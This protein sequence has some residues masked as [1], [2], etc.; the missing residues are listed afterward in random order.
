[1]GMKYDE[2]KEGAI[3]FERQHRVR[4][5]AKV[6]DVDQFDNVTPALEI[7]YLNQPDHMSP[8]LTGSGNLN[9][10]PWH[11]WKCQRELIDDVRLNKCDR[12]RRVY[13]PDCHVCHC[14]TPWDPN[15]R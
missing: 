3:Y 5:L 12:C 1:M 15:R 10:E 2:V 9:D 14:D 13:C 6:N 7:E 8:K 11:C 4:V